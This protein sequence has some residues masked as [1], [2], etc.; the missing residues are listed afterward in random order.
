MQ[1]GRHATG[2]TDIQLAG[3]L[4]GMEVDIASGED[5]SKKLNEFCN[6]G[7]DPALGKPPPV[8]KKP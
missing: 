6:G 7:C 3:A 4:L 2:L 8:P 5:P 1:G